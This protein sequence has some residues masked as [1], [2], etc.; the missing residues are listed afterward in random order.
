MSAT[1]PIA[2]AH[3]G[4]S[5]DG[6]ENSMA[7]FGAAVALGYRH[8]ETDAR[9]TAD[10]VALAFHDSILDRVTN[11]TGR[12]ADLNWHEVSAARIVDR[13]PIPRLEDVLATFGDVEVNIDVKSDAA[14]G[15]T[16][17]AIRRTGAWARVRLAAFS[18]AR[19]QRLRA[20]AGPAVASALSPPEVL[21][22][23]VLER[24]PSLG[25]LPV[26]ASLP[27]RVGLPPGTALPVRPGLAAQVPAA[28]GRFGVVTRRFVEAAHSRQIAVHVW[29]VNLPAEM[30]RLLDLGVDGIITDRADLLR[31]VLRERGQ[32]QS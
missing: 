14:V 31:E 21:S 22:L 28:A 12:L 17:D 8:L 4:F 5:R 30:T 27:G 32:W 19:L 11:H 2:L 24:A 26:R 13:E 9:V 15:P 16:I 20:V 3:R 10:G 25:R 7:A 29:T 23:K 18:H 1:F 6:A